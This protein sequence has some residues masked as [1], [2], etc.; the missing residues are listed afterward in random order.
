MTNPELPEEL[1]GFDEPI[2]LL[3]ACHNKIVAHCELIEEIVGALQDNNEAFD[4]RAAA[5]KAIT[6]FSS[7]AR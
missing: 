2:A 1:P 5:R 7:S 3:R 6:Y 4:T